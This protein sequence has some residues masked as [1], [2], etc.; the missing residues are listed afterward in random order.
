MPNAT[1]PMARSTSKTQLQQAEQDKTSTSRA[2]KF[3]DALNHVQT[4]LNAHEA[5]EELART[6]VGSTVASTGQSMG[7]SHL[8]RLLDAGKRVSS[9]TPER[10]IPMWMVVRCAVT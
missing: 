2:S 9:S 3:Q 8:H 1:K 5:S 7:L 6:W 4:L 10:G